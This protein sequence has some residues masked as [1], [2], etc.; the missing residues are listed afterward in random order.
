MHVTHS[1]S[2]KANPTQRHRTLTSISFFPFR[3]LKKKTVC[4]YTSSCNFTISHLIHYDI[5]WAMNFT[6]QLGIHGC[7][8][9]DCVGERQKQSSQLQCLTVVN[10]VWHPFTHIWTISQPQ[11]TA[12]N[13]GWTLRIMSLDDL[14]PV[15]LG[16]LLCVQESCT[17]IPL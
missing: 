8:M 17:R 14:F 15:V 11:T 13:Y 12:T 7:H 3:F 9:S 4:T 1:T 16:H 2:N 5:P 10:G 6:R